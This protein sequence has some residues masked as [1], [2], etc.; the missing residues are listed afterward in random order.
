M[1]WL[2][3]I[4][5]SGSHPPTQL[6][7]LLPDLLSVQELRLMGPDY[8]HGIQSHLRID[9]FTDAHPMFKASR[10]RISGPLSRYSSIIVDVFYDHL[11]SQ[12][13]DRFATAPRLAFIQDF[14]S[15]LDLHLPHL[16]HHAAQRLR[17]L[18]D[19]DWL[20]SYE[21][22]PGIDITLQRISQRLRRPVSLHHAL[23]ALE[24][25]Y[26]ELLA[27]FLEFYPHLQ[28]HLAAPLLGKPTPSSSGSSFQPRFTA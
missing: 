23:P 10:R 15:N 12:Q 11:L 28:R 19:E 27:D 13:W 24:A 21:G 26:T 20:G 25:S 5:L 22:L 4:H 14:Y 7:N 2:A 16:P 8:Q 1:N 9:A 6:G 17:L 3:H 18:R